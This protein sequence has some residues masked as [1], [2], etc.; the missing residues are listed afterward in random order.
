MRWENHIQLRCF[1]VPDAEEEVRIKHSY[2][3]QSPT[4]PIHRNSATHG[5]AAHGDKQGLLFQMLRVQ[6]DIR[7]HLEILVNIFQD[8]ATS[9]Q[10]IGVSQQQ[11][12]SQRPHS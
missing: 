5:R 4:R 1:D 3:V 9:L 11:I 10:S 6:K 2:S 8:T 7:D 12:V